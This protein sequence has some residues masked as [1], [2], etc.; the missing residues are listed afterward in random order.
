MKKVNIFIAKRQRGEQLPICLH[1][2]NLCNQNKKYNVIV[3]ITE[4]CAYNAI[5]LP[6]YKNI[7]IE[8]LFYPIDGLFNKSKLLNYGLAKARQDFDWFSI[9][10]R[11]DI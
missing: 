8:Y 7:T 5:K 11:Y 4:D 6:E 10:D 3:Y 1:Y 2:L 9:I